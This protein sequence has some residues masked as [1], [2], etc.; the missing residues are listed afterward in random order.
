MGYSLATS[1]DYLK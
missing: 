1:R